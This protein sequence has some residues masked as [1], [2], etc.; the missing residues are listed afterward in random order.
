MNSYLHFGDK[1]F[2][3]KKVVFPGNPKLNHFLVMTAQMSLLTTGYFLLWFWLFFRVSSDFYTS[4][5]LKYIFLA[6]FDFRVFG[7]PTLLVGVK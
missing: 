5:K 6:H 2:M 1:L 3:D 7:S 4:E